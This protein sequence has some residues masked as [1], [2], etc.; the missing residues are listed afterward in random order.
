MSYV[1]T[2]WR[3]G[4]KVTAGK[5]NKMEQGIVDAANTGGS[6]L[7]EI[8]ASDNG[9]VLTVVDGVWA[10]ADAGGKAQ[11]VR[12]TLLDLSDAQF[13][14]SGAGILSYTYPSTD[15]LVVGDTYIVTIDENEYE[16]QANLNDNMPFAYIGSGAPG[17]NIPFVIYTADDIIRINLDD[18]NNVYNGETI[19]DVKVEHSVDTLPDWNENDPTSASYIK[20]RPFYE[21]IGEPVVI[22]G[23]N[24]AVELSHTPIIGEISNVYYS[25]LSIS[26]RSSD[27][28][29][30]ISFS[31]G[32]EVTVLVNDAAH[33][34]T[35]SKTGD[36]RYDSA[37]SSQAQATELLT[38]GEIVL[39]VTETVDDRAGG[40]IFVFS[41]LIPLQSEGPESV[42]VSILKSPYSIHKIPSKFI[43]GAGVV[44]AGEGVGSTVQGLIGNEDPANNNLASGDY[45]H[46]EGGSV[47]P[48]EES[49]DYLY[50][51]NN[52]SGTASHA[53]GANT[54]ASASYSHAEGVSTTAN[55]MASHA[56]GI[57]T[58]ASGDSSHAEGGGTT[59]SGG[60]SHA[61]GVGTTASGGNSHAEGANTLASGTQSHAEGTSTTASGNFSHAEGNTTIANHVSQHVFGEYNVADASTAQANQRGT[62]VEIVGNGTANGA[63]ASRSNARTLDWS[64][65][66]VLAGKLT[67]G[68]AP[69]ADM[70]VATKKYVDDRTTFTD[71]TE[72]VFECAFGL[73]DGENDY[74]G[75]ETDTE[76]GEYS[77]VTQITSSFKL[78]DG[79]KYIVSINDMK[80]EFVA[81]AGSDTY[82]GPFV[83][84]RSEHT[85]EMDRF[86]ITSYTKSNES[87]VSIGIEITSEER[88]AIYAGTY[89]PP[90]VKIE[91]AVVA[92]SLA[93]GAAGITIGSTT[94]TEAQLQALLATLA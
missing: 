46:A 11:V 90:V 44:V 37:N 31:D 49:G 29:E 19:H 39:G 1:P 2:Q 82:H 85:D 59:A 9:K 71:G 60:N 5:L 78:V 15:T 14:D 32:D 3:T 51:R 28:P 23:T 84:I 45:A 56:E 41:L 74:P 94:I 17:S 33:Y 21:K 66:E 16:L 54:T 73:P 93:V 18:T 75:V 62:Y 89:V 79:E 43:D 81:S 24:G 67:V 34:I 80:K 77:L 57:T 70:D 27:M 76:T 25:P 87:R 30:D 72:V 86:W 6:Q 26:A 92:P 91:Q 20:N 10:A 4:D 8:S 13:S 69:T 40:L 53:E 58:T 55:G 50:L 48:D 64:G 52:A 83:E 7:P 12:E 36:G 88:D 38:N 65:N 42:T 47:E 22:A 63:T 68:A 61:E 35:V